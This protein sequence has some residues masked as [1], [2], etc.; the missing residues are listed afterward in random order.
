MDKNI[1]DKLMAIAD[2]LQGDDA[3]TVRTAAFYL[4]PPPEPKRESF[5]NVGGVYYHERQY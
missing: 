2:K 4:L 5:I 1:S 3:A